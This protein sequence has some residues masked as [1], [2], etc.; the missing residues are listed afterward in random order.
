M[1]ASSW[2]SRIRVSQGASRPA[3]PPATSASNLPGSIGLLIDRCATQII[4]PLAVCRQAQAWTDRS[5]RPSGLSRARSIPKSG[6]SPYQ[7]TERSSRQPGSDQRSRML[8]A[9]RARAA[10]RPAKL[11]MAGA[12]CRPVGCNSKGVGATRARCSQSFQSQ[13]TRTPAARTG[14]MPWVPPVS[15]ARI[16][17]LIGLRQSLLRSVPEVAEGQRQFGHLAADQG[18]RRLQIVAL[19]AGHSNRVALD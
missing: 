2:H 5:V 14:T 17:S 4:G 1:P 13:P 15:I 19:G 16:A 12:R 8:S 9:Q 18:D 11:S 7:T 6:R 10:D 3:M